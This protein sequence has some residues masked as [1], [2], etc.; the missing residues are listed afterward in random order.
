MPQLL[1]AL[2][3][4]TADVFLEPEELLTAPYFRDSNLNWTWPTGSYALAKVEV[5]IADQAA[6]VRPL[7][8]ARGSMEQG[9]LLDIFETEGARALSLGGF[10]NGF[11]FGIWFTAASVV[12]LLACH[13]HYALRKCRAIAKMLTERAILKDALPRDR[14]LSGANNLLQKYALGSFVE[15]ATSGL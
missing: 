13:V 3:C 11:V 10:C 9:D 7:D 12:L 14:I 2:R 8:A 1:L 5:R 4:S 15:T 6:I